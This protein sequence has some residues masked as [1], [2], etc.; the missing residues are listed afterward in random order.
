MGEMPL[1]KK[2]PRL[3]RHFRQ[4]IIAPT[5]IRAPITDSTVLSVMTRVRLLPRS[6]ASLD[7]EAAVEE[8]VEV[9]VSEDIVVG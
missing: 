8:A 4:I 1:A 7:E 2:E 9:G 5:T 3:L 6:D